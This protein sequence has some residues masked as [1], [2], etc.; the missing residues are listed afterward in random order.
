MNYPTLFQPGNIGSCRL[1]NRIIM[2]L[3]PTKYATD[4]LVNERMRAFYR[5][6][7]RG[8]AALIVLDCPCLD[9]PAL[10]KGK[11]EL[12]FDEEPYAG[13]IMALLEVIHNEGAKA[14]MHLNYPRELVFDKEVPG[15]KQK[16]SKWV[17]AVAN[18][19]TTE[20]ARS[21]IDVMAK[22][23]AR[24]RELG[25]DGIDLQAG[26]GD[27]IAQLLSPL[28]NKRADEFGGS[29]E[30]RSRFPADLIR[31]IKELAGSDFPVM[32]KLVC[33][34]FTGGGITVNE[35]SESV[36]ILAEAGADAVVANAGNKDTKNITIPSHYTGAGAL[37]HIAA[38]I[39][40]TAPIPVIA[41]GKI[42]T[43]ELAEQIIAQ[44]KADFVA[45]ARALVA[46]PY[47]PVKAQEG[48]RDEIRGCIYCLQDCAQQGAPGI[49]RCCSV[50]PFTG[51]EDVLKIVPAEKSKKIVIVGGGPAGMQAAVLARQRG[52]SVTLFEKNDTLGGQFLLA[53]K[54]P[55]KGEVAELL[56][57]L[58]HMVMR[59]DIHI[60]M[61]KEAGVGD[62]LSEKPDA[63]IIATGSRYKILGVK[64]AD[65]PHVHDARDAYDRMP[66]PGRHVVIVGGGDIGCETADM[67]AQ[68]DREITI[69]EII[70]DVLSKMKDIPRGDLLRRLGEK[71]VTILTERT[72]ESFEREGVRIRDNA[73][74]ASLLKSDTVFVA[75]GSLSENSLAGLLKDKI[76]EVIVIG[77]ADSPGNVGD[78][79]RSAAKHAL[80]I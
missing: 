14:F 79:L 20:E 5:A 1:R 34:E 62:I 68:D 78:A 4:S 67:L 22:G 9:Y 80:A 3:F 54:A 75:A 55:Y 11:N 39:K 12:R 10:Y 24:A 45:M 31:E 64:G 7:A 42:N 21:I 77:D 56:R 46:D 50:N 35:S 74:N 17:R 72:V 25:Y 43:P 69:L 70:P 57:Y 51:R 28:T 32:I 58:T 27:L 61:N 71:K 19:M 60:I 29:L 13:S 63:V 73:G 59:E 16:G 23:A 44:G 2:P 33:D 18:T 76:P 37:V 41:I 52:H 40:K 47:L 65:L 53:Y 66:D 30:N 48:R 38:G 49:G 36:R 26:Y 15:A 6:R 8:G